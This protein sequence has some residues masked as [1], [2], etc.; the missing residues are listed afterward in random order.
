VDINSL[1]LVAISS[2][3]LV[4]INSPHPVDINN[5]HPVDINNPHPV[6]HNHRLLERLLV[7]SNSQ[8]FLACQHQVERPR[9]VVRPGVWRSV[10]TRTQ[11]VLPSDR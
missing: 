8:P 3:R 5:P 6:E 11:Q 4:D 2:L 7:V 9:K 10:S 1:R